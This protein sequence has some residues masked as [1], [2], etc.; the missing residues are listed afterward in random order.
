MAMASSI[1]AGKRSGELDPLFTGLVYCE[2]V[3]A[4]Q[5][6]A[7][8]DQAEEWTTAME[9]WSRGSVVARAAASVP[10]PG[11]VRP[12]VASRTPGAFSGSRSNHSSPV[13][14]IKGGEGQD[15]GGDPRHRVHAYGDPGHQRRRH[16]DH[17]GGQDG[18][19]QQEDQ[20]VDLPDLSHEGQG[21][22]DRR[23]VA[24]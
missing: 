1:M 11:S 24:E 16:E 23:H 12:N 13:A 3:C 22:H 8:Y 19:L 18:R 5:S 9:R 7:Q 17:H 14:E 21:Q 15:E 10:T 2:V 20:D 4:F 6:L